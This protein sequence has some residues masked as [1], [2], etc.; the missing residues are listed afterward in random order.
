MVSRRR[1]CSTSDLGTE[2]ST[3][4]TSAVCDARPASEPWRVLFV[5]RMDRLKG[6]QELLS[7]RCAL[8]RPAAGCDRISLSFAGDGPQRMS[9]ER[10]AAERP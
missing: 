2:M 9:W 3:R 8:A 5:G 6:G 7:A 1:E 4:V 10:L